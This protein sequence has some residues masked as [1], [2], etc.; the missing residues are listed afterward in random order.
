MYR[1]AAL[2]VVVLLP[3][4]ALGQQAGG[5]SAGPAEAP[6][7]EPAAGSPSPEWTQDRT[8]P[9]TRFW[10]LDPGRIEAELWWNLRAP[11]GQDAFHLVKAELEIGLTN[12]I[13]LDLYENI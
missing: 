4:V 11:R 3:A 1:L 9:G 12:R 5:Y 8:F 7:Y 6:A 10:K 2:V 13:Q